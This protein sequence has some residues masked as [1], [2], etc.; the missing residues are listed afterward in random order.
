MSIRAIYLNNMCK[1]GPYSRRLGKGKIQ[2]GYELIGES[3][4]LGVARALL[5]E[6][7]Q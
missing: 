1:L 2:R 6:Y 3:A 4:T 7:R 5:W